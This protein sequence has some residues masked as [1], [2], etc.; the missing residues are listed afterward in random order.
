MSVSCTPIRTLE[1]RPSQFKTP[2]IQVDYDL[3]EFP[4]G[5]QGEYSVIRQGAEFGGV[6]IP[7]TRFR[8]IG[9]IGLARQFRYPLKEET[10]EFPRGGTDDL[11]SKEAMRELAEEM[12]VTPSGVRELGKINPDTG[13]LSMTVGVWVAFIQ[14]ETLPTDYEEAETG[15]RT[16]WV[17]EGTFSGMVL[18]GKITCGVTLA[19]YALFLVNRSFLG[20]TSF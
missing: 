4:D 6:V 16:T 1:S 17:S 12:S 7:F 5:T 14:S 2:F 19:A 3:V 20:P 11:S 8:G 13:I 18:N 10:L 15:L 9:Y